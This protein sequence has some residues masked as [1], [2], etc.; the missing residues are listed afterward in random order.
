MFINCHLE[1]P[2]TIRLV[3]AAAGLAGRTLHKHFRTRGISPMR[4]VR[5]RRFSGV[6]QAL[7]SAAPHDSVT[8]IALQ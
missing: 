4:Y 7:L 2:L 8:A 5:E 6:R 3:A 1:D